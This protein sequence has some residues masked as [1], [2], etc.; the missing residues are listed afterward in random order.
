MKLQEGDVAPSFGLYDQHGEVHNLEDYEGEWI[1]LYF[2]PKDDTP[3]CTTEACGFRDNLGDLQKYGV[4]LGV[5]GDTVESHKKFAEKYNLD[6]P[7]LADPEKQTIE[8]YGADGMLFQKRVTF[9][10]SPEGIIEK[11]Y[12]EVDPET[13][14]AQIIADLRLLKGD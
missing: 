5:S 2:Y 9:L 7:L 4:L 1:V 14:A 12:D 10:I 11:I 8:Q 13:H 6:Y 3:G